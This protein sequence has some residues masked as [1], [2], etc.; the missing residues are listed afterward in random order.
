M[1]RNPEIDRIAVLGAESTGKT[2]L[3]QSLSKM[4][5][6]DAVYE[7]A[8]EYLQNPSVSYEELEHIALTQL[9]R[10]ESALEST[11]YDYILF[12]TEVINLKVWFE[13][14]F[15][16]VPSFLK[17]IDPRKRYDYYLITQMDLE[18]EPDPL[19]TYTDPAIR[20]E[21]EKR[22]ISELQSLDMPY[23]IVYGQ[24]PQRIK[25]AYE[26]IKN[27]CNN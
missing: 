1:A 6:A 21:L 2:R 16:N 23:N 3:V 10:E 12:D 13:Y 19:R 20:A 17:E 5:P 4:L 7:Y 22:Y 14:V 25:R 27:N 11:R 26:S 9:R 18:Y 8:R 15:Q 24:G